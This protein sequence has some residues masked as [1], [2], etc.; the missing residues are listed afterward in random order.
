MRHVAKERERDN[1]FLAENG[2][3]R[4]LGKWKTR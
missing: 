1:I 2:E 4:G 3:L